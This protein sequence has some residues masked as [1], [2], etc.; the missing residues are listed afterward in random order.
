MLR[1]V[2]SGALDLDL[3]VAV[4][5]YALGDRRKDFFLCVRQGG[6]D[7]GRQLGRTWHCA[8]HRKIAR[9]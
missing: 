3:I 1:R 9:I 7:V 4:E 8:Q 2:V 6:R 5:V